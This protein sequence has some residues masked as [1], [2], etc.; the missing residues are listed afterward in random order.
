MGWLFL[1]NVVVTDCAKGNCIGTI[2]HKH[3]GTRKRVSV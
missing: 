2:Q 1:S 3:V